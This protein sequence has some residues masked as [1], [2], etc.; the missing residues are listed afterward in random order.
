MNNKDFNDWLAKYTPLPQEILGNSYPKNVRRMSFTELHAYRYRL[1]LQRL[2]QSTSFRSG[3]CLLDIGPFPGGWVSLIDEHFGHSLQIDMIG[4]GMTP[5]FKERLLAPRFHLIDF[6]VDIENPICKNPGRDIPLERG[7][8]K[9][10][11][12][13]E[14]I[15]H[16]YNPLP[17]LRRI[18]ESLT[19]DGRFIL[20]TDNPS[21]FGFAYQSLCNKRSMWGPVQESHLF[22]H[23]DWRPHIRLYNLQDL[24]FMLEGT[25]MQVI[26][27][28]YFND[29]F[30]LYALRNGKLSFRLGTKALRA[31]I[32]SLLLPVRLW[33]NRILIVAAAKKEI[34][35][36]Q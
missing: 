32:P 13:L 34:G 7:R 3:D 35:K 19:P 21:W 14:T 31:K 28:C 10:V 18:G 20:T 24:N 6:D 1:T 17:L 27:S 30:G 16:L 15:E 12:L 5:E 33:A 9:A 36:N 23:G 4:L 22:Y 8:Y 11:S 2:A 29:N 26:D 25:G